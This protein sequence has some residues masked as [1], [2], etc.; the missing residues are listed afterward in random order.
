V[1]ISIGKSSPNPPEFS[2]FEEIPL[3]ENKVTNGWQ[4]ASSD[5]GTST[6]GRITIRN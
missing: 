5:P 3:V 6:G 4:E 2:I 1:N